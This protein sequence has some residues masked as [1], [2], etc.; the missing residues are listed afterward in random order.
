[1]LDARRSRREVLKSLAATAAGIALGQPQRALVGGA[2]AHL[3]RA[4]LGLSD[5]DLSQLSQGR[6]VVK[7]LA[8][9]AR[10]EVATGGAIRI[11]GSVPDFVTQFHTLDG[12]RRS[13][14]VQQIARFSDP[15]AQADLDV[16]ALE[17][18]DLE[19][20]RTCRAGK[21]GLRLPA[22]DIHRFQTEVDW[23]GRDWPQT[24]GALLKRTLFGYLTAYRSGGLARLPHYADD[25]EPVPLGD[26]LQALIAQTPSPLDA[27]PA[28][29]EYLLRYP[30]VSLEGT[31][32]FFYWS[33]EEFGFKPIVGLNHVCT[34]TA[35]TG[36]VTMAIIQIYATHYMDAQVAVMTLLPDPAAADGFYWIYV[37]RARID[38][39]DGF[40]GAI[41]RPIV[42]RRARSGLSKSFA[43]TKARLEGAP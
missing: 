4:I 29:R 16:L 42:Q 26:Q 15:P 18:R 17:S 6:P 35:P 36:Q 34:R 25:D 23:R 5:G 1:M 30:S 31:D 20:L 12:F 24:S 39:L 41:S 9:A 40:W 43:T 37:N 28:F 7:T 11:R 21:C 19:D 3:L 10:R 22:A 33:K 32:S 13:E 8:A 2:P 27:D 14:F 38:R